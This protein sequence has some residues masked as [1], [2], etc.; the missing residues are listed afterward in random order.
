MNGM[1][2]QTAPATHYSFVV[3]RSNVTD[4]IRR[5]HAVADAIRSG[6]RP[7]AAAWDVVLAGMEKQIRAGWRNPAGD[8]IER[9]DIHFVLEPG[10]DIWEVRATM[11]PV[12]R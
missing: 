12:L 10:R 7:F 2:D 5:L 8:A 4:Q 9:F 6:A 1:P 3:T 11:Q